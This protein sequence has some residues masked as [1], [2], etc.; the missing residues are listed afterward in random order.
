MGDLG[1]KGTCARLLGAA[2]AVTVMLSA[3]WYAPSARADTSTPSMFAGTLGTRPDTAHAESA[4]GIKV[5]MVEIVWRDY[6]P[7]EGVYDP[8]YQALIE[9]RIV[10]M[11]HAGM[12][13]TLGLGLHFPPGWAFAFPNSRF[14]N[15]YGQ[16]SSNLNLVFNVDLRRQVDQYLDQI[17]TAFGLST[18]WA[19][20]LTSGATSEVLYPDGG[21]YWAFDANAQNGPDMPYSMDRNPDPGWR[22][23]GGGLS[24]AQVGDWARWYVAALDDTV[25][26]QIRQLRDLGFTGYYQ[27][28]T[29][30]FGVTP[31]AFA[32][33][34]AADLPDG[35]LGVG[36]AWAQF[37]AG[38]AEKTH[39]V[40]YVSSVGDGSGGDDSCEA[41]DDDVALN[42]PEVAWWSTTRWISRIADA[43][44]LLKAGEVP[45][46]DPSSPES[47]AHYTD[48]SS[49]GLMATAERQAS[50]CG[51]QGLYWA[52]DDQF[53]GNT[54]ALPMSAFAAYAGSDAPAP[55]P[56]TSR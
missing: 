25:N 31:N 28:V 48:L 27:L 8:A 36:A 32:D 2:V 34:A 19:V 39:V 53:H 10:A 13:I 22:P 4:A 15:Q 41:G 20:R 29:P 49:T 43:D 56:A 16:T 11:R 35:T 23:G 47:A 52:H 26:W 24:T 54:R 7:E 18:F 45:G 30:G 14:V 44:G 21:S 12:R 3:W 37:Y 17:N 50:S 38:V 9:S 33:A 42:S 6:E 1:W 51:F 55:A 40:A 5:G 46:Y